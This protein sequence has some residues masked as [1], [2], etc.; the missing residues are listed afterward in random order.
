MAVKAGSSHHVVL[1][2]ANGTGETGLMLAPNREG[3]LYGSR[4]L[5]ELPTRDLEAHQRSWHRGFGDYFHTEGD[6][7]RYAHSDGVDL[8]FANTAQLAP[9]L[10]SLVTDADAALVVNGDFESNA[11]AQWSEVADAGHVYKQ[12]EYWE[13]LRRGQWGKL[14]L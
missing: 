5:P 4:L 8:R 7:H 13:E 11:L 14:E 9:K 3:V 12:P 10:E 1:S 6:P 2:K